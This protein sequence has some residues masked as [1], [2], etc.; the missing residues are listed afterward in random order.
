ML[1]RRAG[2]LLLAIVLGAGL[3]ACGGDDGGSDDDAVDQVDRDDTGNGDGDDGSSDDGSADDGS[4]DDDGD[5][6]DGS[7]IEGAFTGERCA[8][9]STFFSTVG[10]A[11]SGSVSDDFADAQAAFE[12]AVED[13]PEDVQDDFETYVGAYTQ[14]AEILEG[15]G[16]D[17]EDLDAADFT[18][19]A[20]AGALQEAGQVI[21]SPELV[22][23][24][25]E[26]TQFFANG[27]EG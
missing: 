11:V 18:D 2:A 16:I 26:I 7:A 1:A 24:A 9:L 5:D 4:S 13:V 22:A 12:D 19:P 25:T 27:C 20:V 10:A 8:E 14:Y 21:S 17:F 15:A 3:A 6:G 23:A